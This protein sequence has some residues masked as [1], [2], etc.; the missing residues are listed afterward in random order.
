MERVKKDSDLIAYKQNY[1]RSV[2]IF[3]PNTFYWRLRYWINQY[4]AMITWWI[5][6]PIVKWNASFWRIKEGEVMYTACEIHR[7]GLPIKEPDGIVRWQ[8]PWWI[9]KSK[10]RFRKAILHFREVL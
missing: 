10:E 7:I 9:K 2:V 5:I 1:Y 8:F 3:R 4:G 6:G